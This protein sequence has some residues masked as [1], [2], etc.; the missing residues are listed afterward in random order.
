MSL[1]V[2]K[3]GYELHPQGIFDATIDSIEER[4]GDFGPQL[5]FTI[6]TGEVDQSGEEIPLW[7][8]TSMKVTPK[9]K[10]AG[11]IMDIMSWQFSEIP[12]E[13]DVESLVEKRFRIVVARKLDNKGV[14][15]SIISAFM[16]SEADDNDSLPAVS[17]DGA[18]DDDILF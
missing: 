3:T 14:T 2:T 18:T 7:Y 5:M 13:F 8:W 16:P 10:L 9:S 6:R 12:D 17:R 4:E 11:F 15:R 1:I